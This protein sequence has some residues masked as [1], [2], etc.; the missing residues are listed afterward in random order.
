MS[1]SKALKFHGM[2]PKKYNCAQ[3]IAMAFDNEPLAIELANAGGGKAE[4]GMCGALY[5]ALQLA[6][7]AKKAT[8]LAEFVE[9]AGSYK[10]RELKQVYKTPCS[11][12]IELAEELLLK[13]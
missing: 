5:A 13:S 3:S 7:E 4:D 2:V 6:D 11:R 12:A 1:E 10:C 9:Q 8:I